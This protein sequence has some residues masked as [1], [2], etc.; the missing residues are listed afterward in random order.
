MTIVK[1]NFTSP[2]S[3]QSPPKVKIDTIKIGEM[4]V[5]KQTY[6]P[7]W[8]WSK[9]MK[10]VAGTDTCQMHHMGVGI[11]GKMHV[12]ANDGQ[13]MEFGPGDVVDIPPGHDAWVLGD[14]PVVLYSFYCGPVP[15]K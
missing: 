8:K 14:Q 15:T 13:E 1:K 3:T 7:G 5:V 10:P 9:D 4:T 6:Q 2:D 12:K 11:S